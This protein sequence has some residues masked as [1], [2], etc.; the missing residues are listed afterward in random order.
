MITI[1]APESND[2]HQRFLLGTT[3]TNPLVVIGLNP[4]Y[5]NRETSDRTITKI[6][7]FSA[8]H[9]CDSFIMIN[10]S[11]QRTPNPTDLV[12]QVDEGLHRQNLHHISAILAPVNP[13]HVLAA[14]GE[15][16]RIRPYLADHLK[17][18]IKLL[19]PKTVEWLQIGEQLTKSGHPRHPSRTPYVPL[20][21]FNIHHYLDAKMGR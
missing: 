18:I 21:S 8:N 19:N 11:A 12:L 7:T 2:E 5:A 3:G 20:Q 14:W 13:V 17:D 15:T 9:G 16:I 4:S 1:Y 6:K 10:L